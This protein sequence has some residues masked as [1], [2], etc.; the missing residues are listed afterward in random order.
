[1]KLRKKR[2]TRVDDDKENGIGIE[3]LPLFKASWPENRTE[4]RIPPDQNLNTPETIQQKSDTPSSE[5]C[6]PSYEQ[7]ETLKSRCEIQTTGVEPSVTR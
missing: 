2:V 5:R 1:M 6:E 7:R 3:P 4:P